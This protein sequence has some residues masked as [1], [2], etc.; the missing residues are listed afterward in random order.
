MLT[1]TYLLNKKNENN[2]K[3]TTKDKSDQTIT[4]SKQSAILSDSKKGRYNERLNF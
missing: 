2:L 4:P 3:L 1:E